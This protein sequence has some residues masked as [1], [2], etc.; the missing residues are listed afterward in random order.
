[1]RFVTRA[2]LCYI[3]TFVLLGLD[4]DSVGLTHRLSIELLVSSD[5]LSL[6][7]LLPDFPL[8]KKARMTENALS[9]VYKMPATLSMEITSTCLFMVKDKELGFKATLALVVLPTPG[10]TLSMI[11]VGTWKEAFGIKPL[12]VT[13][14]SGSLSVV[15]NPPFIKAFEFNAAIELGVVKFSAGIGMLCRVESAGRCLC[16]AGDVWLGWQRTKTPS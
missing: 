13:A 12:T 16:S 10:L 2:L 7:L 14:L 15:P 1:M 9:L 11:M 6:D 5:R 3:F 4:W 8:G